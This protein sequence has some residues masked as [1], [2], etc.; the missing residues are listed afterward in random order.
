MQRSPLYTI[1]FATAVCIVCAVVVSSAAVSLKERQDI[2][3]ALEK[4]RNVLIAAGLLGDEEKVSQ[5]EIENR[6]ATIRSIVIDMET[7]E[8]APDIDPQTFDQKKEATN[9]DTSRVAPANP[10][11]VKR[12]PDHALVY[13]VQGE[14]G[15]IDMIILPVE[16]YGLWSTL[17]G[18]IALDADLE[19]VRG[20]TFYEHK[21]TPGLGG[22]VDNPGWKAKWKGRMVY[23]EDGLPELEVIK[24]QA[25]PPAEDPFRVDGLS[26]ATL[27]SRGVTNLVHF[28]LGENGFGPLLEKLESR[29]ERRAA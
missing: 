14:S 10:A 6:F 28:W 25:G 21:E 27:T 2:N 15:E 22:E 20:I 5:D 9:P 17:Y 26:G 4:Q 29:E 3:S 24:G 7:G 1:L 8:E 18:F 19:T 16:G 11:L 13:L 12:L 23:G